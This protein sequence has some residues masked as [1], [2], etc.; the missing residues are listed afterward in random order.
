MGMISVT[1]NVVMQVLHTMELSASR[2]P[3]FIA[4]CCN[5]CQTLENSVVLVPEL[6]QLRTFLLLLH[7]LNCVR[8]C[9]KRSVTFF[10]CL[11][12]L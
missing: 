8:F 10:V 2:T 5:V 4:D 7:A 12:C 9:F 3:S 11:N 1:K 6:A